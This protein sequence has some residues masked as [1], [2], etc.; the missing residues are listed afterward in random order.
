MKRIVRITIEASQDHPDVLTVQ[1]AMQQALD[2]F[3]LLTDESNPA[4]KWKL[5]L[6]S[7]NS[8][9][10]VEGEPVDMRTLAGAFGSVEKRIETVERNLSRVAQGLDFDDSFPRDKLPHAKRMLK[11]NTN[12]IGATLTTFDA[13]S[14]P[15]AFDTLIAKRFFDE[16]ESPSVSLHSYLF[17]RTSRKEQGSIEGKIVGIGTDYGNPAVRLIEQKSGREVSC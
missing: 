14:A 1:D 2:F 11:R 3:A 7:T 13:D 15:I 8:P 16:V 5:T 4:V 12:G 17:S 10:T 6:A 9:L